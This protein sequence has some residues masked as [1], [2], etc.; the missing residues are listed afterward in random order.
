MSAAASSPWPVTGL[1]VSDVDSTFL[2]QEVIELVAEHAGVR[3]R[4]E[5][6]TTAAMRGDLAPVRKLL[7]V[8]SEPYREREGLEEYAASAPPGFGEYRT[9]CGT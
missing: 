2:T 4:V 9:F 6:I 8:M 7:G 3:D 5:E 1:L